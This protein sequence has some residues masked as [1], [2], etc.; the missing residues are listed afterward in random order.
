MAKK[1]HPRVGDALR[2]ALT[3]VCLASARVASD[4]ARVGFMYREKPEETMDSGW[5]FLAGDETEEF[6]ENEEN[7]GVFDVEYIVGIDPLV[8]NYIHLPVGTELE[9]T[10][11]KFIPYT[12]EA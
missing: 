2:Q 1:N 10:E 6:L 5:R 7:Y 11:G 12:E 9:R 3:G 4:K 8:R